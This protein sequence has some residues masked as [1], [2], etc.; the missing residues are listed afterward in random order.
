MTDE[1]KG[2]ENNDKAEEGNSEKN[3]LSYRDD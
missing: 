3:K 1:V 2:G